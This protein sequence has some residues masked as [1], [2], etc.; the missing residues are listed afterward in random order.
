MFKTKFRLN[1]SSGTYVNVV[2]KIRMRSYNY[3]LLQLHAGIP[4]PSYDPA[5]KNQEHSVLRYA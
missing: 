5:D 4:D 3:H 1:T 2:C